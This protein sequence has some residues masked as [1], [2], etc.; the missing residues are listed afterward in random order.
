[1]IDVGR[2]NKFSCTEKIE[3]CPFTPSAIFQTPSLAF[4]NVKTSSHV[5]SLVYLHVPSVFV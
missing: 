1:M 3:N 2:S 5:W 4:R